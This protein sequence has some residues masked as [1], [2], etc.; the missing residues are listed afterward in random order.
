MVPCVSTSVWLSI[1][2]LPV[3]KH[4][5]DVFCAAK[6]SEVMTSIRGTGNRSTELRLITLMRKA[7]ITGWRRGSKLPGRPDFIFP[8]YRVA[9]FVDGDFWHG[10]P[11]HFRLPSTNREFWRR[12]IELNRARDRKVRRQLSAK[13]WVVLR[14]WESTLRSQHNRALL[15]LKRALNKV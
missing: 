13:G 5:T 9:V 3:T 1:G 11:K 14:I 6:R 15:R 10:H 4:M 2:H 7:G 12:K 8:T